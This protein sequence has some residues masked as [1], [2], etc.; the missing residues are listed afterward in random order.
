M[1]KRGPAPMPTKLR[2]LRGETRPSQINYQ[3]PKPKAEL[4]TRPEN[5]G[6]A[7][8][9]VW[10]RVI[11]TYAATGVLT[12]VDTDVFRAYCEAVAR[13]E[14]A[15]KLLEQSGPLVRGQRGELVKNPLH[16]VV[17]DNADLLRQFARELGLTPAS[18]S[19]L[20]G[21]DHDEGDEIDRWQTG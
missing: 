1:G 2:M 20:K 11:D 3:E 12:A 21:K 5:L 17:R 16:Q 8:G 15:A 10:D 13:Y 7:A 9:V 6:E 14:Y 4:P 18:R 19:G